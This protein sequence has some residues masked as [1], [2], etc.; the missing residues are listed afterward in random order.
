MA[1]AQD[2]RS[3]SQMLDEELMRAYCSFEDHEHLTLA[4]KALV[5][6]IERRDLEL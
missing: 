3:I 2:T 4:Q 1:E 5:A 6:E